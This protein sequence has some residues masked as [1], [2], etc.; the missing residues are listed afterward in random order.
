M[1]LIDR[2]ALCNEVLA[3]WPFEAQC[4]YASQLG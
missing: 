1:T 3:P 2:L 4:A